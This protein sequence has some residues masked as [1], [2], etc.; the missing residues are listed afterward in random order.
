MEA[1]YVLGFTYQSRGVSRLLILHSPHA[2]AAPAASLPVC[3]LRPSRGSGA[4]FFL[5]SNTTNSKQLSPSLGGTGRA[6]LT[7]GRPVLTNL[8]YSCVCAQAGIRTPLKTKTLNN[9]NTSQWLSVGGAA[10]WRRSSRAFRP[11]PEGAREFLKTQLSPLLPAL[12][13]G[14]G[15]LA[16]ASALTITT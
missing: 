8:C 6:A 13:G 1:A 9:H 15:A 16:G 14:A 12:A 3:A 7:G 4:T 11:L 2:V 10:P 5:N